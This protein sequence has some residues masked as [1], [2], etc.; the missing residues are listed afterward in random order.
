[1]Q[2][3]EVANGEIYCSSDLVARKFGIKHN[4]LVSII[5]KVF[6]DYPDLRGCGT[7]PK[8]IEKWKKESRHYRGTDFD[9]YLMNRPFFSLVTMRMTSKR[10]RSWQREFNSAFY[11]MEESLLKVESNKND[12][13]WPHA[14]LLGK[15][16]RLEETDAIKDFIEYATK[17]GSKN[18]KH[19]YSLITKSSYRAL[20]LIAQKSPKLRD[21]M[22]GFEL[23][24]L[25]LAERLAASKLREYMDAGRQYKDIYKSVAGDLSRYANAMRIAAPQSPT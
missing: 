24:E 4:A 6:A 25:M 15:S 3:V 13:E 12:D 1:M 2:I 11:M 16:A 17:Q 21:E 8:S 9:V 14:R 19:Y 7:S 20:G 22:T 5:D 10:A 18:A 23:A